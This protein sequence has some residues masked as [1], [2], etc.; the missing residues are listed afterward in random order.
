MN[1]TPT[2]VQAYYAARVPAVRI[3]NRREWRGPCPVH[4][5]KGPNF[6]VSSET[7]LAQCHS[8]CGRGWDMV[9]LEMELTGVDFARAKERVFSMIGR[10]NVP[11]E[12]RNVEAI[13]DYQ[14]EHGKL[15]YQVL[16]YF[17]K[18]F[19][20]RRPAPGGW[21]WGL[22]DTPRVPYRLAKLRDQNFVAVCE[23]EKDVLTLER[24]DICATC[25]SGG[26]GNFRAD[27]APHFAGKH[28]AIF[29]D[30]DEPGRQ[31]ALKVAAILSPVA[32]S[33]KVVEL[34]R[35]HAKGDV[36]DFVNAGGTAD[37]LRELYR[38][39]QNWTPDCWEFAVS[40]PDENEKYVRTV[41]QE[42]E[43]AGGLNG[44]WDLAKF[45]GLPTPFPKLNWMLVEECETVKCT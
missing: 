11:W 1:F 17:G 21:I 4:S 31:H 7:G 23:G 39:A 22:G 34:P 38:K 8:R 19:K 26:A 29:P 3:T 5:G 27:L 44:F 10:P 42:I 33:V 12:E 35:L 6:A 45:T 36:T 30:N 14:D 43:A 9:S 28:I 20:Q 15:L 32:K 41:E 25:N 13:Y 40:V 16:R 2:E 18:T 37:E 24:L